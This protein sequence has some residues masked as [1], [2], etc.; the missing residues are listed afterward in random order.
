MRIQISAVGTKMPT[1]VSTAV[2]DYVARL[3]R[4]WRLLWKEITPVKR[5][6]N[7]S[8]AQVK[9][10]EGEKILQSIPEAS[11]VIALDQ[12]GAS[13]SSEE[14]AKCLDRWQND[15]QYVTFLVGG[16]DGLDKKCLDKARS[17]WSL[18]ALTF[19]HALI[20]VLLVEQLYRAWTILKGHPYHTG[21]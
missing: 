11:I 17:C 14:L 5:T 16:S 2:D 1:W 15:A 21:H 12:R 13:W 10:R 9:L 20:R 19:P 8:V 3:P 6:A 7:Y 4:E 18:S